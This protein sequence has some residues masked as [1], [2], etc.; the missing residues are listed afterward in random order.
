MEQLKE[1]IQKVISNKLKLSIIAK[2]ESIE[3]YNNDLLNDFSKVQ[4]DG[5][6]HLAEK[7][8]I[9]F[10]EKPEI[11]ID[12]KGD[13]LELLNETVGMEKEFAKKIGANFGIRQATIHC[14]ADDEKFLY[15][16]NKNKK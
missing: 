7:Y 2:L 15:H 11:N 13:L 14:L 5:G 16:L 1:K 3:Q 10:N 6:L 4:L 9:Y 12:N 8:M